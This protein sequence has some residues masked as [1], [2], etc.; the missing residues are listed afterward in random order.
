VIGA[1]HKPFLDAYLSCVMDVSVV[2][3]E[4]IGQ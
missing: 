4:E 3:L 1:S 2:H